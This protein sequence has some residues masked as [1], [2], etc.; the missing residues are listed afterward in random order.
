MV[1]VMDDLHRADEH[2]RKYDRSAGRRSAYLER[3][4]N[5]G[6]V[7][8]GCGGATYGETA[9]RRVSERLRFAYP[10]IDILE[11]TNVCVADPGAKFNR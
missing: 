7:L 2:P 10:D 3:T 1:L 4:M 8:C 11:T 6:V 5:I 9:I